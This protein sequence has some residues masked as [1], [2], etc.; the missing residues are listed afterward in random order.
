[1]SLRPRRLTRERTVPL[2][3]FVVLLT[4]M[5]G[6]A[7][8]AAATS[9]DGASIQRTAA[10]AAAAATPTLTHRAATPA[11]SRSA[12][13][14]PAPAPAQVN[15]AAA[16]DPTPTPVPPVPG[17]LAS[18]AGCPPPPSTPGPYVPPWH[19]DHLVPDAQ[20]PAPQPAS[21]PAAPLTAIAGKGLWVWKYGATEGGNATAIASRAVAGG[22]NQ[23]W[24]RVG[25][26]P[27][28]FY[29]ADELAQVVPAAHAR[30]LSVIAWGFPYLY[31]PVADAAWTNQI[32]AW[33]SPSGD[34]V[35]GFSPDIE[36]ASEGVALSALRTSVYLSLVRP[37][38]DGRPLVATVYPPT[39]HWMAN[40]P[41]AAMAPYVDAF[42]PMV[43][44]E[45]RDPGDAANEAV[46]RL[47]AMKPVHV[48][49]QAFS[50]GDV[51]GRINQP[52]TTELD[53]FMGVSRQD[54][55]VGASF[56]VWQDVNPEEWNALT[57]YPWSPPDPNPARP[58]TAHGAPH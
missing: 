35:D 49:G 18:L 32:L 37:A 19:P 10:R 25:D 21:G 33:R 56:W 39:D 55:A 15:L 43:Y 53:R 42:A 24:V 34:R 51:G 13:H 23:V 58:L 3:F 47:A 7:V 41:Y 22:L 29:G 27:D 36:T 11:V 57:A 8:V 45:C 28:G 20:L 26:S 52:S 40:Y 14:A 30:G 9:R 48:I 6:L 44:W 2:S 5:G 17:P 54:G 16:P 1:M 46:S 4:A 38:R 12:T 31:D 50:F